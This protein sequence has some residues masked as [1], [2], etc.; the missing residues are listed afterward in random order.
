MNSFEKHFFS[1][2]IMPECSLY[3]RVE[4]R[5]LANYHHSNGVCLVFTLAC[6]SYYRVPKCNAKTAMNENIGSLIIVRR[7]S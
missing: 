7:F 1:F 6:T 2:P 3:S 4:F 5:L